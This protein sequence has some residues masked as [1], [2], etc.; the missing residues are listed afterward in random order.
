[1]L[2]W[3][4]AS[5]SLKALGAQGLVGHLFRAQAMLMDLEALVATS[6]DLGAKVAFL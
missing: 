1:M 6:L 5:L 2:S 3:G 4:P